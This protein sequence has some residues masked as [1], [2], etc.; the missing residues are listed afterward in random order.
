MRVVLLFFTDPPRPFSS[1]VAALAPIVRA[2]G[3]EP[4]AYEVFRRRPID[5]V[6]DELEAL[7]PDVVGVSAMTRDWPGARAL[8][9]RLRAR[10]RGDGGRGPFIVVGGYHASLGAA[11]VAASEAVDAIAI[12]DGERPLTALLRDLAGGRAP[13]TG[14]GLWVRGDGGLVGPPPAADPEPDLAALPRWDYDV[15]GEFAEILRGGVNTFGPHVDRYLPTRASRGCPFSCAYC[16]APRWGRL[17]GF[18]AGAQ[19][20]RNVRPVAHLC[21]ELAALRERY[22]PEGFEFWDEHFPPQLDW[23]RE[24]AA[25]YPR[26]VGLPFK[27]EMHPNAATRERL[28]LLAAAGCALFH[29]GI[30]AGDAGLR[31]DVLNRRTSDERL[32]RLFD[33]CRDLGLATSASLMTMLPGETRAQM[34]ATTGLLRRLRPG[35]FMWSTYQALPGTTLGDAA[36]ESWPG[37]ARERFDDFDDPPSRTPARVD[38]GE[39]RETFRELA[40]LQDELVQIAGWGAAGERRARP[41]E[42]PLPPRPAPPRLAQLLG[43]AAADAPLRRPRVNLASMDQ[44]TLVLE[45]EDPTF[46]PQE[47]RIAARGGGRHF[48]Q[49]RRLGLSY[50]GREAPR[51]LLAILRAMAERLGDVDMAALREA[52]ADG[53]AGEERAS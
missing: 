9:E 31:V 1:S 49:S 36:T 13:T 33:D 44:E 11:D 46:A 26:R 37:P 40:A 5:A 14:P 29:C 18:Q 19:G 38:E 17:Q 30:E 45:I 43:L 21:D 47:I 15:F 22:D 52:L 12:G 7:A 25:V 51:K 4:I 35:S 28:E 8:I 34:R 53:A 16:S 48:A 23:L 10:A 20:R 39:R 42:I 6:A 2:A 3:H 24:F 27:V 32:Q 41:V 50:R